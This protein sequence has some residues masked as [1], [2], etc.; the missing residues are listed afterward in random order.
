MRKT[1]LAVVMA[2]IC[3]LSLCAFTACDKLAD[4]QIVDCEHTWIDVEA[5][6]PTCT[7]PG[8]NAYQYCT[9]CKKTN[10]QS[11]FYNALGHDFGEGNVCT[12]CSLRVD[13]QSKYFKFN[14]LD[15]GTYE[16]RANP[17][18]KDSMPE[19]VVIPESLLDVPV[20]AIAD[21]AFVECSSIAQLVIPG[22]I[23]NIGYCPFVYCTNLARIDVDSD[24]VAYKSVDGVLYNANGSTLI[25]YPA[26][27]VV[28]DFVVPAEVTRIEDCAFFASNQASVTIGTGVSH[29]GYSAFYASKIESI[30]IP[31]LVEAID[32]CAFYN[33]D[34]LTHVEFGSSVT[35]IGYAAFFD[36]DALQSIEIPSSVSFIGNNAFHECNSLAWI[37][38]GS[39]NDHYMSI[40]GSLYVINK[41]SNASEY[42]L[43]LFH[44]VPQN[45]DYFFVN[46][47]VVAIITGAIEDFNTPEIIVYEGSEAKWNAISKGAFS[48]LIDHSQIYFYSENPET[49]GN[50]WHYDEHGDIAIWVFEEE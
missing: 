31:D 20:T 2:L 14:L 45:K 15:D 3:V 44:C 27:K 24:N 35:S 47:K 43:T 49:V 7:T 16:V 48:D 9:N 25:A 39:L 8:H 13:T 23:T 22:S 5:V 18:Y 40:D 41:G 46:S 1:F 30:V 19:C 29:I 11:V 34:A 32:D 10:P 37:E 26:Q 42:T 28:D 21:S 4:G 50:F 17:A 38:A 6:E 36:C 12:R 33:C